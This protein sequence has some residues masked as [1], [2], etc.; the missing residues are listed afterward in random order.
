MSMQSSFTFAYAHGGPLGPVLFRQSPEDF[1]VEER[2][3]F[4]P[5]GSGE[6]VYIQVR[7]RNT[8][9][10]WLARQL[11]QFAGL[12]P[13]AVSYAGLKDRNAIAVQ[14]FSLHMPKSEELDWHSIESAD[15]QVLQVLRHQQ[16]LRKGMLKGNSFRIR[17]AGC[18]FPRDALEERMQHIQQQGVPNYFGEQRFGQGGGNLD[19]ARALFAGKLR[20]KNRHKRGLYL[21]AARSYLFNQVLSARVEQG[22]WNHALAGE[23]FMLAGSNSFFCPESMDETLQQ[24]L[25]EKDI[26]TSGPLWGRG[27]NPTCGECAALEESIARQ[28][29]QL[30]EGLEHAGL[31][32]ER[33]ALRLFAEDLQWSLLDTQQLEVAFFLPAGSYATVILREIATWESG[34]PE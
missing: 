1:F 16:K 25:R 8:N 32:Q 22:S 20:E 15:L 7:K 5:C 18:N 23:C 28:D 4:S 17:L 30:C 11:A 2:L 10:D 21:S 34:F 29:T 19:K 3:P 24:R 33:R 6:H 12:P 31:K 9:T 13:K 27:S 14:W 26:H